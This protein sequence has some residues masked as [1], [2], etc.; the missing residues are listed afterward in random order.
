MNSDKRVNK[1]E[2]A[3][4]ATRTF[5]NL[6]IKS[7][8]SFVDNSEIRKAIKSQG[9][10]AK[11]EYKFQIDDTS[12][13]KISMSLNTLKSYSDRL[14]EEGFEGL[15]YL[16][17]K[18][19]NTLDEHVQRSVQPNSQSK[20]GLKFKIEQLQDELEKHRSANFVLLQA[21]TSAMGTIKSMQDATSDSIRDKRAKEG[22]ARLRAIASLNPPP[23]DKVQPSV[24][25]IK[26][27]K[28]GQ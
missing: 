4:L 28:D 17:L 24:V 27:Y 25:S 18:A 21:I 11:L 14:F 15:N 5:L 23:F 10:L 2:A 19:L 7:P 9:G 20:A 12:I 16:R 8:G 13:C 26:D 3:T 22:L 6:I 1:N